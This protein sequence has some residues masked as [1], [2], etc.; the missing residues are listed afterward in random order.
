MKFNFN[1][2]SSKANNFTGSSNG[3]IV[4]TLTMVAWAIYG[5]FDH[6]SE[7][8]QMVLNTG[9]SIVTFVMLFLITKQQNKD[10]RALNIKIDELIKAIETADNNKIGAELLDDEEIEKLRSL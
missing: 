9:T 3:I 2:I 5:F 7:A 6:Y 4:A 1:S 8:S 10:T